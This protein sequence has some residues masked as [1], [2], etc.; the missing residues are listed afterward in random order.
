MLGGATCAPKNS[1]KLVVGPKDLHI[2][3]RLSRRKIE[4]KRVLRRLPSASLGPDN[5]LVGMAKDR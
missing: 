2:L 5:R 3:S 1:K 4:R